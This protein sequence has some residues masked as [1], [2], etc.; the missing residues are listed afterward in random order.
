MSVQIQDDSQDIQTDISSCSF[1]CEQELQAQIMPQNAFTKC[2]VKESKK[3]RFSKRKK[4]DMEENAM[5]E[6]AFNYLES[7]KRNK[8]AVA[9]D[10]DHHFGM[11]I[12]SEVRSIEDEHIKNYKI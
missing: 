7:I 12:A 3:S 10:S 6:S 5:L 4:E 11:Y 9:E 2:P 8:S 1:E